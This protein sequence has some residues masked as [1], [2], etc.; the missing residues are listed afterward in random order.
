METLALFGKYYRKDV[1]ENPNGDDHP[2]IRNFI[3]DGWA[4]IRFQGE[5]LKPII[6]H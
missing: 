1:M 2:N 4:A 5:A 3:L 6:I